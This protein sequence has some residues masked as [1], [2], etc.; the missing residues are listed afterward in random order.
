MHFGRAAGARKSRSEGFA[1]SGEPRAKECIPLSMILQ[2]NRRPTAGAAS[3]ATPGM[4]RVVSRGNSKTTK[5]PQLFF[6]FC[7][8]NL[9]P[10]QL[11]WLDLLS[12]VLLRYRT[13]PR[14]DL[15]SNG[16]RLHPAEIWKTNF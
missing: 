7:R 10:K 14:R 15:P 16:H 13:S 5:S 1:G 8:H 3:G 12:Y 9:Q 2:Q 4:T 11:I 6:H